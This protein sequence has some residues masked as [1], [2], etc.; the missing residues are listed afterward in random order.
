MMKK[1]QI[2]TLFAIALGTVLAAAPAAA[3]TGT[4]IADILNV[5]SDPS[6]RSEIIDTLTYGD[7][8]LIT[9][10]PDDGWCEIY[11]NGTCCYVCAD[12]LEGMGGT[13][14]AYG[15]DDEYDYGDDYG[16]D[17]DYGYD[18]SDDYEDYGD[19]DYDDAD[20]YDDDDYDYSAGSGTYLG[21]FT[22]TAYCDCALC[23]GTAGNPT[24]SGVMATSGHTVAMGGVPFG[25][26]LLI[27][28]HVYTVEDRGTPY[29]HVD[30]F[31][32][33]HQEASDFG[34]QYAD[35]YQLD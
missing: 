35:I 26:R 25:T 5:R 13:G 30:I 2:K 8:V 16:Y 9:Y 3:R 18:D 21:T 6:I 15:Y 4:V 19:D 28:G 29:G 23:C 33:S 34:L 12:Y 14:S 17:N 32:D 20:G 22:L 31:F 24:A 10:G 11:K 27:N 7:Q 1:F